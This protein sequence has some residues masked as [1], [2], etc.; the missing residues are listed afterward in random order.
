M[1]SI[2]A[3]ALLIITMIIY[4]MNREAYSGFMNVWRLDTTLGGI[5]IA[6]EPISKPRY[7]KNTIIVPNSM[8]AIHQLNKDDIDPF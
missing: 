3:F 5:P 7:F 6:A 8:A 1:I 4:I 2:I